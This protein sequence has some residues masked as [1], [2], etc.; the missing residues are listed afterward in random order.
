VEIG[1]FWVLKSGASDET[2]GPSMPDK[3][4]FDFVGLAGGRLH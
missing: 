1:V 4:V 2:L 3:N